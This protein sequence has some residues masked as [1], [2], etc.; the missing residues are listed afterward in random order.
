MGLSSGKS[1]G[2]GRVKTGSSRD[3]IAVCTG[4]G[5]TGRLGV[6]V[7]RRD[8]RMGATNCVTC[9]AVLC[10]ATRGGRLR[11]AAVR[12]A[13]CKPMPRCTGGLLTTVALAFTLLDDALLLKICTITA[14]M[15]CCTGQYRFTT[16]SNKTCNSNTPS[17][18]P[19]RLRSRGASGVKM[20]L[21]VTV[22]MFAQPVQSRV[23]THYVPPSTAASSS[24]P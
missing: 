14:C 7:F 1:T 19:G 2:I 6:G 9:N 24:R 13:R 5:S 20:N 11:S 15:A 10:C 22:L 17:N 23:T 18:T 4:G 3:R 8:G 21:K 12:R 16:H